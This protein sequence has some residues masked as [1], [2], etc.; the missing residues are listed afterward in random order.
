M[1]FLI[2]FAF[3][4]SS[5]LGSSSFFMFVPME[6]VKFGVQIYFS[7]SSCIKS[8][9][10]YEKIKEKKNGSNSINFP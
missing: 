4:D 7:P 3:V 1:L 9:Q 10:S 6:V 2:L 8:Y 5:F